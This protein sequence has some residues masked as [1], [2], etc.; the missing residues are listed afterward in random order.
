M[1][2]MSHFNMNIQEN[3]KK[4]LRE[5][6]KNK[7]NREG[8]HKGEYSDTLESLTTFFLG[9]ENVCDVYAMYIVSDPTYA[10]LVYYNG[11]SGRYLSDELDD[12]LTKYVPTVLFS[13]IVNR[14]CNEE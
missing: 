1:Q 10:V 4:T 5:E 2:N 9:E 7:F 6:T 13:H 12:F 14:K 8:S 11:E 3:I